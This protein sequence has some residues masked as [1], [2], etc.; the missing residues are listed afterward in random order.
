MMYGIVGCC[1][2]AYFVLKFVI[3]IY[4]NIKT[5]SAVNCV[6]FTKYGKW[7][8]VTGATDGIGK[9]YAFQ[10]ANKGMSIVLI[11]RNIEKLVDVAQEI[12]RVSK[13]ETKCVAIDF[14]GSHEIYDKVKSILQELDIGV[15][16][17][18]VGMSLGNPEF[19]HM[20]DIKTVR[21][22]IK[23]NCESVAE[24]THLLI[25]KMLEKQKGIIINISSASS[26]HTSPLL[27]LYAGSKH[28]VTSLSKGLNAEYCSKG[29]II[30]TVVPY[31][32]C[33]KMSKLKKASFFAPS[34]ATYVSQALLTVGNQ[35]MTY[36]CISH[37]IMGIFL[38]SLP[39]FVTTYAGFQ[40]MGMARERALKKS[41]KMNSSEKNE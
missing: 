1:T 26:L 8:I 39:E 36:G 20:V 10:L 35:A 18:N 28:F 27:S 23:V 41:A 3:F 40:L 12:E 16:V 30:Q 19:H 7:A 4:D 13:V 25:P 9:E 2:I 5:F 33:T 34:A 21:N 31:F 14:S 37:T 29:L 32:V 15:L 22:L 38:A 17:N 11:S 6:D 24:M